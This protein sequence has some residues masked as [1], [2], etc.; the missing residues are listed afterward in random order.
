MHRWQSI[1][2][3]YDSDN[4]LWLFQG[5][6]YMMEEADEGRLMTMIYVSGWMFLLVPV[7]LGWPGQNP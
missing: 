1:A 3:E 6:F 2:C 4:T 5:L 7:H